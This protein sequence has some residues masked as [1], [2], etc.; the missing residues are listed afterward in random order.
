MLFFIPPC[1]QPTTAT[2]LNTPCCPITFISS[3]KKRSRS[4][5]PFPASPWTLTSRNS[6]RCC[7][8]SSF[9]FRMTRK[10]RYKNLSGSYKTRQY[11]WHTIPP[12]SPDHVSPS[13]MTHRYTMMKRHCSSPKRKQ[14]TSPVP[15]ILRPSKQRSARLESLSS[16]WSKISGYGE[17]REKNILHSYHH[18][19][20]LAQ[21]QATCGG[22]HAFDI[23]SLQNKIQCYHLDSKGI[24]EYMDEIEDVQAK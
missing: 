10:T 11:T 24:P 9:S 5:G 7:H 1:Q 6:A 12:R 20:M 18:G 13:F 16:S 22:I 8:K 15:A 2:T 14:Y 4:L 21:L 17:S 23:L 3:S 19:E